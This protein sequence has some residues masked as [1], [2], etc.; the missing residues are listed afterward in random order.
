MDR[1]VITPIIN[2]PALLVENN[3][4]ALVVADLHL[5]IEAHLY[6]GGIS[7]PSQV[8]KRLNRILG[9]LDHVKPDHIVLLGD[10]KHNVPHTSWQEREE[11]PS[12]LKKLADHARVDIAPGNH[13]S[14]IGN[15]LKDLDRVKVRNM[16]GFILDE[17]GYLHGHTWPAPELLGASYIIV[18]HNHPTLRFTDSLGYGT[19]EPVWI[20]TRLKREVL[21]SHYGQKIQG[22]PEIRD[23]E[24]IIMPAF[25]ELCGG[26]AFNEA[27]VGCLLG[28]LFTS[29]AILLEEALVYLLDGTNLGRLGDI[30][31]LDITRK[32][33]ERFTSK[34]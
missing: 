34:G 31:N 17:V 33:S 22:N 2:E 27:W 11:L 10:V 30:R 9:Y 13:D 5:G 24:V 12:F 29:G 16:R 28:P 18:A 25:N 32:R 8:E 21:E 1:I 23:S 19:V 20:R 4:R 15:L 6:Q 3:L 26:V 14:N 7:I